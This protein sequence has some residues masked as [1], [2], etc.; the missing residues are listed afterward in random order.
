[1]LREGLSGH[2]IV[3]VRSNSILKIKDATVGNKLLKCCE[4]PEGKNYSYLG[5]VCVVILPKRA[6]LS[7]G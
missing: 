3:S 2:K 4:E 5:H 1:V 6:K 7:L